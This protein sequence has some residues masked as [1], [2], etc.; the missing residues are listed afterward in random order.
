LGNFS[1]F[2]PCFLSFFLSVFLSFLVFT[3]LPTHCRCRSY[4]C[5]DHTQRHTHKFSVGFLWTR[6]RS[7]TEKTLHS[8][9]RKTTVPLMG[10]EIAIPTNEWRQTDAIDRAAIGIGYLRTSKK[11]IRASLDGRTQEQ[12]CR[13]TIMFKPPISVNT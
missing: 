9:N 8:Y 2:L 10:F 5:I 3:S 7:V 11:K 6:D 4:C 12:G 1:L 13:D